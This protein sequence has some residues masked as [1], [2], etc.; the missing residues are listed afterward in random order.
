MVPNIHGSAHALTHILLAFVF[1][2]TEAIYRNTI[3]S[4]LLGEKKLKP[5]EALLL[6][7][8]KVENKLVEYRWEKKH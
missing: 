4:G 1:G 2:T 7:Y 8:Q 5:L 3:H 6:F